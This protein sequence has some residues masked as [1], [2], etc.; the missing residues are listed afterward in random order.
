MLWKKLNK[1]YENEIF[2]EQDPRKKEKKQLQMEENKECKMKF[3]QGE[4]A[5]F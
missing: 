5:L 2:L 1:I 3:L 4:N